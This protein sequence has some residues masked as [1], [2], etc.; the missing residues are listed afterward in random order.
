MLVYY[1]DGVS[2]RAGQKVCLSESLLMNDMSSGV[3]MY[4]A[5]LLIEM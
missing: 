3:K 1:V 5:A 2:L 4:S